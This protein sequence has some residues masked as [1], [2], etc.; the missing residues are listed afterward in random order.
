MIDMKK[1][2]IDTTLQ[3]ML[4]RNQIYTVKL[5]RNILREIYLKYGDITDNEIRLYNDDADGQYQ[6]SI[7]VSTIRKYLKQH[8]FVVKKD[9]ECI[10]REMTIDEYVSIVSTEDINKDDEK[11]DDDFMDNLTIRQK[12]SLDYGEMVA[13]MNDMVLMSLRCSANSLLLFNQLCTDMKGFD[14]SYLLSYTIS[15]G[16]N[17]LGYTKEDITQETRDNFYKTKKKK[18]E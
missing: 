11:G 3:V 18:G 8:H 10:V 16:L 17:A 14:K 7:S 9:A 1:T 5:L 6:I 13:H 12:I 15:S 4:E 2:I